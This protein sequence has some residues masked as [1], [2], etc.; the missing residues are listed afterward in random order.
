MMIVGGILV[1]TIGTTLN[2][3]K[4]TDEEHTRYRSRVVDFEDGF[5]LIDYPAHQETGKTKFFMDG[6]ELIISFTTETDEAFAFKSSVNGRLR[7]SIPML[8]IEHPG[9]DKF[10]KI[11]RREFVRVDASLDVAVTTEDET[12]QLVTDDISAGGLAINLREP[13]N[14]NEND[15]VDLLIV[16]PF[17]TGELH[18]IWTNGKVVRIWEKSGRKIASVQFDELE[19]NDRQ[20]IIQY[21]FERQLQL[22]NS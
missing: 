10:T 4:I 5:I 13:H 19:K 16:L 9:A 15:T 17:R 6:T 12:Y 22:R 11:Q 14:L 1:L 2:I 3:D 21:C 8:R 20:R 7:R 18:Y